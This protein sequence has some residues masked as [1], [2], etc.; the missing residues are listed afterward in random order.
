MIPIP[1]HLYQ[2]MA[3]WLRKGTIEI[4][5]Q[6]LALIGIPFLREMYLI[7]LPTTTL[8][9]AIGCSGI[10][11]LLTYFVFGMAYAYLFRTGINQR[12]SLV[13]LT[14]PISLLA[15]SLRLTLIALLAYCI[16]P[17]MAEYWPHVI[18]SWLV[19]FSVLVSS[20]LLDRW[21][22]LRKEKEHPAAIK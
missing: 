22:I 10:R 18:A 4:S 14:I 15:S 16:G 2:T 6:L 21:F 9:V 13:C 3:D 1:M 12:I 20:V 5:T 8:K 7:H 11:Y 19:F 17:Y